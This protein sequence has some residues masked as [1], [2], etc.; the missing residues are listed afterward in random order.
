MMRTICTR[1][2][3]AFGRLASIE[4]ASVRTRTGRAYANQSSLAV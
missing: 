4:V 1:V 2:A 3:D